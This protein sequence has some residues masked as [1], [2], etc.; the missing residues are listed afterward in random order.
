MREND[1][2]I[3]L[4]TILLSIVCIFTFFINNKTIY[5]DIMESRNIVTA[6]EM[7]YDGHWM[8]PTMNGDLRLEKPPLPTWIT[9]AAEKISPDDIGLQRAMAGIA[10][11]MLV[12]FFYLLGREITQRE[13][14]AWIASLVLC[15]SYNIVLMG[16][17]ASW[18]IYCHAFMMGAIYFIY[19]TFKEK[20]ASW[21]SSILAGVFLGLS[22]M[23]KGPISFYGLLL[24]FLIAFLFYASPFERR[25]WK[26]LI[27]MI[28]ICL[29]VSSW[30]YIYIY[31]FHADAA[32]YV[33]NKEST[34]WTE[35][36]VRPWFYY[37]S[38]FLETGVWS[39]LTI[40]ALL[41]PV[42]LKGLKLKREY[43]M[44]IVWLVLQLILLSLFPEKKK[45]Y[46]LP[47]L[48]P[49]AYL[50]GFVLIYWKDNLYRRSEKTTRLLFSINTYLVAAICLLI[51][52]AG[53][54]FILKEGF[55]TLDR[56]LIISIVL[57]IISGWLFYASWKREP[58]HFVYGI[59]AL[60]MI[61][62]V[63]VMP[64][65]G[66]LV[67]NTEFKSISETQHIQ[68]LDNIPFYYNKEKEM[69]IEIIYEAHR[70]IKPINVQ[71]STA[72][73]KALPLAI[74]THGNVKDELPAT[75]LSK[76]STKWIGRY[77]N[78]RRPKGTRRYSDLFIYNVT[79][80]TKK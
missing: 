45:R 36:N 79:I 65:I 52:I 34:A 33:L 23:S 32:Q 35:R 11:T 26:Q 30:W 12:F 43:L 64:Y 56:Y 18:D 44:V 51:P 69:R 5:P 77:D 1:S 14:F 50:I 66:D 60:F 21:L 38:F 47:V 46:L 37:W 13:D 72:I 10:A 49:I 28:V 15:T 17:T 78:N 25:R 73:M 3:L 57:I 48:I 31:I 62:E 59:A 54:W 19:C 70:K 2:H 74:L 40:T 29:L 16:R 76:L 22:F 6:R 67:N 75:L 7:V 41:V 71:D 27:A 61:S 4:H 42:W 20:G 68:A 80:L 8:V 24:P 63:L 39:L 53:Y 9:A 55:M 58:F